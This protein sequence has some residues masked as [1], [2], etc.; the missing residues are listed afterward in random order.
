MRGADT[1][2][3]PFVRPE[4]TTAGL[5]RD[6]APLIEG[7]PTFDRDDFYAGALGTPGQSGIYAIPQT[8]RVDLLNY[9]KELWAIR[10]LPEPGSAFDIDCS[11]SPSNN[12]F[13]GIKPSTEYPSRESPKAGIRKTK[14]HKL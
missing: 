5:L 6:L 7:D 1:V 9:N 8:L 4:D 11:A 14:I 3:A 12:S 10:G 2:S 13:S